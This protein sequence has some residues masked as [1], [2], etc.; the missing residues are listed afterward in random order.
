MKDPVILPS[1]RAVVD[2]ATI[3]SHLL[4]DVRDPFNRAPLKIEEVIPSAYHPVA[5]FERFELTPCSVIFVDTELKA[6]I[7]EF[8]V[9]RRAEKR[10]IM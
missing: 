2:R 7:D 10:T 5:S 6:R 1:S 9:A 3:K 4:S 8:L